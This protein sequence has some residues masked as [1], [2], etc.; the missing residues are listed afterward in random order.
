MKKIFLGLSLL[1]LLQAC[2]PT[3]SIVS[4]GITIVK[5]GG[6]ARAVVASGTGLYIQE[7]TGKNTLEHVAD[8]TVN[9][10]Q[11]SCSV[12]H[13]AEINQIFFTTL[14]EFD[15]ERSYLNEANLYYLR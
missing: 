10:E 3:A 13:S 14:D 5:S 11:R 7:T 1:V 12:T 6:T 8:K 4:S 15:C 9:A 2:G